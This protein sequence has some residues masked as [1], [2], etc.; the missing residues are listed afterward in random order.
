ME[1]VNKD[2]LLSSVSIT[3]KLKFKHKDL[4]IGLIFSCPGNSIFIEL[5]EISSPLVK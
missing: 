2:A 5:L 1:D 4:I 3:V